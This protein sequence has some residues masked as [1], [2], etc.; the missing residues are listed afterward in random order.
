MKKWTKAV[1]AMAVMG[2]A[3]VPAHAVLYFNS[4]RI[5][6]SGALAGKDII[7]FYAVFESDPTKPDAQESAAITPQTPAGATGILGGS[8]DMTTS[9]GAFFFRKVDVDGL[10]D[11]GSGAPPND[12]DVFAEKQANY[13]SFRTSNSAVGTMMRVYNASTLTSGSGNFSKSALFLDGVDRTGGNYSGDNDG[14]APTGFD[15]VK[16]VRLEGILLQTKFGDADNNAKIAN[17]FNANAAAQAA[18]GGLGS[19]LGG[20]FAIA[21]F[22]T[23]ATVTATGIMGANAGPGPTPYTIVAAVPEPGSLAL[24]GGL[25]VGMLGRRRRKA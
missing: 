19:G 8:V 7:R 2:F 21:V 20:I 13:G 15:N 3:T 24:V 16:H 23:G 18:N 1:L 22:P 6:G 11:D 12:F 10:P 17:A 9:T 5:T 14:S 25:A 4:Q